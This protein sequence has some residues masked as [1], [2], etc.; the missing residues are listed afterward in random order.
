MKIEWLVFFTLTAR[1]QIF[2]QSCK[3]TL[4]SVIVLFPGPTSP[5][6]V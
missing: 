4:V 5:C 6:L 1:A 3:N 2:T